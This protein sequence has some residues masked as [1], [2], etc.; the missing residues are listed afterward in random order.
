ML[1]ADEEDTIFD[2]EESLK[3][4]FNPVMQVDVDLTVS[5]HLNVKR[6]F[7]IKKKS[8]SKEQ[9]TNVTASLNT[10]HLQI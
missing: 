1:D 5:A 4:N 9:K 2:V 8:Y 6:Y 7:E 10:P 3:E